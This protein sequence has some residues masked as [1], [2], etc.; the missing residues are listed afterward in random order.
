MSKSWN[1]LDREWQVG[2][3]IP[4]TSE[5]STDQQEPDLPKG[6]SPN[7]TGTQ[8][9]GGAP[10]Q[11]RGGLPKT[12]RCGSLRETPTS[13]EPRPKACAVRLC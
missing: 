10:G 2:T 11:G 3:C 13:S 9:A 5:N 1:P 6:L 8:G 7:R 12:P 4:L